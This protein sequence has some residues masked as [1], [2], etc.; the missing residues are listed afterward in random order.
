M[1][2][3]S[4]C[5]TKITLHIT[6]GGEQQS[7]KQIHS[8]VFCC[9]LSVCASLGIAAV[10]QGTTA[11]ASALCTRVPQHQGISCAPCSISLLR[12]VWL[13]VVSYIWISGKRNRKNQCICVISYVPDQILPKLNSKCMCNICLGKSWKRRSK[14]VKLELRCKTGE[15]A[16]RRVCYMHC[17]VPM[18]VGNFNS[19]GNILAKN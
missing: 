19:L 17:S 16:I 13:A 1:Q 2:W 3:C 6:K 10:H 18:L 11:S 9:N 8:L 12:E 14:Q 5:H 7:R 15:L 4:D